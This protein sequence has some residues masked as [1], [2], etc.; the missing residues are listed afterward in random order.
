MYTT[1][2]P[3][4]LGDLTTDSSGSINS[5]TVTYPSQTLP[6]NYPNANVELYTLQSG[7]LG[8]GLASAKLTI[9]VCLPTGLAP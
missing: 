7:Q 2:S 1:G 3:A 9:P 8:T 5:G 4:A 6:K